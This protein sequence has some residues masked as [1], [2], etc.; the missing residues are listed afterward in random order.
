MRRLWGYVGKDLLSPAREAFGSF[1]NGSLLLSPAR[2]QSPGCIHIGDRVMV[3]EHVWLCVVPQPDRPPPRLTIGDGTSINRFV[4]IVC[5]GNVDVGPDCLIGDHVFIADTHYR[6]DDPTRPI[7]EQE[8]APPRPVVIG[9]GSHIGVRA[10]ILPGV[11]LG[12]N[13][14]VGAAAVVEHDVPPRTVVAGHPARVIRRWDPDT[15][16]WLSGDALARPE[17]PP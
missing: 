8:L 5:A 1:G 9:R 2:V 15:R 11:T 13:S 4:K 7:A 6:Y 16:A 12:E 14:Y 3:H 10:M 17:T